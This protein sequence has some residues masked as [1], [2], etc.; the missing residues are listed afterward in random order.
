MRRFNLIAALGVVVAGTSYA[1]SSVTLYG[2]IDEGVSWVSNVRTASGAG[3][4]QVAVASSIIQASRWGLR[5]TEDLGGGLRAVFVLENGFDPSTGQSG[6]GGLEFGRQA[7][8]G[9]SGNYGTLTLGRQYDLV[10]DSV[11]PFVAGT[12]WG[13]ITAAHGGDIDNMLNTWRVNNSVKYSSPEILGMKFGALYSLGGVAGDFSR[14]QIWSVGATCHTGPA[15]FGAAYL[16]VRQPNISFF[17]NSAS[18][19]PSTATANNPNPIFS[20]FLSAHTYQTVAVGGSYSFDR[21]LLG[22]TYSYIRFSGLGDLA[23]GP[24]PRG[25]QGSVA[26]NNVEVNARYRITPALTAG[27]A[28]DYLRQ[29]TIAPSDGATY[30]TVSVGLDYFLSKRTDVYVLGQIQHATGDA[31]TGGDARANITTLG[32][33]SSANQILAHVGM[34]HK[35]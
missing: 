2:V 31:S 17:G 35:F 25:F 1:Q 13:G 10:V 33:S 23:A 18:G 12:Q 20:A 34:R 7:Y 5:G 8:A 16:N 28:Y 14:A 29:G 3:V 24:N 6:Q 27:V 11:G 4:S 22:G 26:F 15:A 32:A 19:T 21:L 30:H 9:L